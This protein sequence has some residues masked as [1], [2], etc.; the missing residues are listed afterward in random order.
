MSELKDSL[1][2]QS[3]QRVDLKRD[4]KNDCKE[5][6]LEFQR[7]YNYA[8]PTTKKKE[9]PPFVVIPDN[10]KPTVNVKRTQEPPLADEEKAPGRKSCPIRLELCTTEYGQ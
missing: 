7:G 4:H 2:L 8:E 3:C 5:L 10:V 9:A 6:T 1:L